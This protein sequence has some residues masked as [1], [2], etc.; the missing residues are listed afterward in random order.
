MRWGEEVQSERGEDDKQ[1]FHSPSLRTSGT[2]LRRTCDGF[3]YSHASS[4][5]WGHCWQWSNYS[6]PRSVW[7][8]HS[9]CG[10]GNIVDVVSRAHAVSR[11]HEVSRADVVSR[12]QWVHVVSRA[13]VDPAWLTAYWQ[14][15][16]VFD[17]LFP[18]AKVRPISIWRATKLC[19]FS[20]HSIA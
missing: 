9:K 16:L 6:C 4:C 8:W 10:S 15:R 3:I 2:S 5:S 13:L 20:L 11:A 17:E 7:K 14:A 1:Y 12:E 18:L 19:G